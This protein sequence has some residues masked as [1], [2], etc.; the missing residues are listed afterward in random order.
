[1]ISV[2]VNLLIVLI[3]F[4]L[5]YYAATL[6]PLPQPFRNLVLVLLI[7]IFVL[8]LVGVL[9]GVLPTPRWP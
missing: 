5:L 6:L 4:G 9:F 1:M 8:L 7:L 3:I 2:L